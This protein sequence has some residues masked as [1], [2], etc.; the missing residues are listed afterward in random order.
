MPRSQNVLRQMVDKIKDVF[1][2]LTPDLRTPIYLSPAFEGIWGRSIESALSGP[3]PITHAVHPNDRSRVRAAIQ[4]ARHSHAFDATYRI[5]RPDGE[6]RWIQN[7]GVAVY[8]HHKTGAPADVTLK[9]VS[10]FVGIA[11]DVTQEWLAKNELARLQASLAEARRVAASGSWDWDFETRALRW[12]D[13]VYRIYGVTPG[14]F[15]ATFASFL[16]RVH[17]EDRAVVERA[18]ERSGQEA[19]SFAVDHR[20]VRPD[21]SV[22]HVRQRGGLV[23]VD[24]EAVRMVGG[25]RDVTDERAAEETQKT[26]SSAVEQTADQVAITTPD[27]IVRFVNPS[28]EQQTGYPA[29]EVIGRT[30]SILKSGLHDR[31]FY[32]RLWKTILD[33]DVFRAEFENRRK[34]GS[35]FVEDKTITP[36]KNGAGEV[37]HFVAVGRDITDRRLAEAKQAELITAVSRGAAEW[38]ATFDAVEMPM[39]VINTRGEVTR[40]N[41][42]FAHSTGRAAPELIGRPLPSSSTQPLPAIQAAVAQAQASGRSS[43]LDPERITSSSGSPT[44]LRCFPCSRRA[45]SERSVTDRCGPPRPGRRCRAPRGTHRGFPAGP[46]EERFRS[47]R[48]SPARLSKV[49]A[50]RSADAARA[51]THMDKGA[52]AV[53]GASPRPGGLYDRSSDAC[54]VSVMEM[55]NRRSFS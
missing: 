54:S 55:P 28:F 35:I 5:V 8:D 30:S 26:L 48:A 51:S 34:D 39:A 14:A 44:R 32:E 36:I 43:Q 11:R 49:N 1:W 16:D 33:G 9:P 20:I 4:R 7:Q 3:V 23:L 46:E 24:G 41:L 31:A 21:G 15:E 18:F 37:T 53:P 52:Y 6:V 10:A 17:P 38:T 22:R 19:E 50:T 42:A 27:G 40:A 45:E 13:E 12:S 25:V 29:S 2:V 47:R